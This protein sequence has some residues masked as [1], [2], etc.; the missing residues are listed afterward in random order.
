[1]PRYV[2]TFTTCA[3]P[4]T[5]RPHTKIGGF[6]GIFIS[7]F[8]ANGTLTIIGGVTYALWLFIAAP[9]WAWCATAAAIIVAAIEFKHWYYNERLLCIRDRECTL[10]TVI[11]KPTAAFD[12]DRKLN[13]M[14]APYSQL[15]IE[16]MLLDHL[17]RNRGML[18]NDS[19]F[20]SPFHPSGA[21][22]LPTKSQM[23]ANRTI[24]KDYIKFLRG[25]DPNDNDARSNMFNQINIGL[26]DT[27]MQN[28][29]KNFFNRFYR[30]DSSAI[31]D[32]AIRD[33]IPVD[34][35]SSINWQGSNAK[36]DAEFVNPQTGKSE[37]LNPM[38]R[39]GGPDSE[40]MVPYLHCEIEGN[41][42][43]ILMNDI[44]TAA[45]GF[46]VGCIL[47]G[48]ILGAAI[49]FLAWLFKKLFDWITGNDGD[50]PESDIDW[51]DPDFT[52]Y[53]DV[54]ETS[55]D[56]VVCY[57]NWIMDTEHHQY[58][59][60]HPVR[61]YYIIARN[62]LGEDEPVLV[63]GNEDQVVVGDN[64]DP[65]QVDRDLVERIC[66]IVTEAEERDPDS[67]IPVSSSVAL[68]YGLTTNY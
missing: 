10:G 31:A 2:E 44:I 1:M 30:K 27:L 11:S 40:P 46:T 22:A 36:S 8:Y 51:D 34:F 12:G 32:P 63:S 21:A 33:A 58:F 67:K 66:K 52:G 39:F 13:L 38:F 60:I 61:A 7:A 62:A 49:G 4:A 14:L 24:F 41:Y 53:P 20:S 48:P 28:P 56:V 54:T 5:A 65:T 23:S 18:T 55:G 50:A 37:K 57:G 9:P 42:V 17:D 26:V 47:G 45:T 3:G 16:L 29:L 43:E 64:F 25:V 68:S 59:E 15:E 35:D 19:N 6:I